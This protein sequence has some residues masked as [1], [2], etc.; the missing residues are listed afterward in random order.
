MKAVKLLFIAL[1]S[2]FAV[3]AHSEMV[4]TFDFK[5]Q[6]DRERAVALAKSLRC[7]QC[8][9][10]N[11][12][13]SN[14]PI[15]YDLRIEV[16]QMVNEGKNNQ[17][18]IDS[19]T[20]RFGQFV[21]Y[22]PPFQWNTWLLWLAPVALLL[23]A[24][25]LIWRSKGRKTQKAISASVVTHEETPEFQF[26]KASKQQQ[27]Q[28]SIGILLAL[29]IIPSAYY[30]SSARL[31]NW[32]QGE[33]L[34]LAAN[35]EKTQGTA[36]QQEDRI[37]KIQNSLRQNPNNGEDW[38]KLGE[39]Y[40]EAEEYQNA[41]TAY[42]NAAQILGETP[43]L[44]GLA[45][46]A[47]YYLANQQITPQIRTLIEAALQGNKNEVS[48]IN[49]LAADAFAQKDYNKAMHLWQQLLDSNNPAVDRRAVIQHMK[50]V[51]I[52]SKG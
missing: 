51:E 49:L 27:W 37:G 3:V 28:V 24:L 44:L 18:I 8:Q 39:A 36:Q 1:L 9:N 22:K 34:Q 30:L 38:R 17:E 26:A 13:E 45:A 19:M 40:A 29:I 52:F 42:S 16:Y 5:N 32:Q 12:V 11:L 7:P 48:A 33:Q 47:H 43:E 20:S 10:Q 31:S 25:G 2:F 50:M 15:A 23:L 14:S 41:L 35:Q 6:A 46:T 4:D 21:N